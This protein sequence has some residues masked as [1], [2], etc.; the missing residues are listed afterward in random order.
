MS[1]PTSVISPKLTSDIDEFLAALRDG[2]VLLIDSLHA[3][4]QVIKLVDNSPVN[5]CALYES[6]GQMLHAGLPLEDGTS[7]RSQPLRDRLIGGHDRTVTAFRFSQKDIGPDVLHNAHK[8]IDNTTRYGFKDL[9][10]LSV[11]CINRSYGRALGKAQRGLLYLSRAMSSFS[12][13]TVP[14][15]AEL[16]VTCSEFVYS[17]YIA[18]DPNSIE[19]SDP[20]SIWVKGRRHAVFERPL[21]PPGPTTSAPGL[22]PEGSYAAA[23]PEIEFIDRVEVARAR[24]PA[25]QKVLETDDRYMLFRDAEP[26][27]PSR[28][29]PRSYGVDDSNELSFDALVANERAELH[30]EMLMNHRGGKSIPHANQ[31]PAPYAQTIT[32]FDLWQSPSLRAVHVLHL[33]PAESDP[34][35]LRS[36]GRRVAGE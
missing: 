10:S 30:E 32:P 23:D 5:H 27:P 34:V 21:T 26:S 6:P 2:D 17:C 25:D 16:S 3:V 35:R 19:I 20:L 8:W 14:S 18:A 31:D 22:D 12:A 1:D 33:P 11:Q 24:Q 9:P 4:S 15:R 13:F 28:V 36:G 29:I 7:V